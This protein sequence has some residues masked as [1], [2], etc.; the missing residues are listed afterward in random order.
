M[1]PLIVQINVVSNAASTK[2][3]YH[4]TP[5]PFLSV[6]PAPC[7]SILWKIPLTPPSS[8]LSSPR[9]RSHIVAPPR[10][11]LY[12]SQHALWL[13]P[14]SSP[15]H[16]PLS[17]IYSEI[18]TGFCKAPL[19]HYYCTWMCTLVKE[20][21]WLTWVV[22]Y[23][24]WSSPDFQLMNEICITIFGVPAP[25]GTLWC[26]SGDCSD[27]MVAFVIHKYHNVGMELRTLQVL[28]YSPP[29]WVY[30]SGFVGH[31]YSETSWYT[32]GINTIM[33]EYWSGWWTDKPEEDVLYI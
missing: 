24:P 19:S 20:M 15:A 8:N 1:Y 27:A 9:F 28:G 23:W 17:T 31:S 14:L 16:L 22:L 12:T 6:I 7:L 33:T 32:L 4:S 21:L 26:C 2:A 29:S 11:P 5:S 25:A 3:Q 13:V 30:W 10:L 18:S